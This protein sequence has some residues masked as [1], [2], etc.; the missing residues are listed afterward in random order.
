MPLARGM[1]YPYAEARLLQAQGLLH[2]AKGEPEPAQ[3][4]LAEALAIF[5]RLGAHADTARTEQALNAL[6]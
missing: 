4:R 6:A 3:A 2:A 1:P 5:Q